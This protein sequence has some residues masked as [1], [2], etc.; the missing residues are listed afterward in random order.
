VNG[1]EFWRRLERRHPRRMTRI[2]RDLVETPEQRQQ[3]EALKE[4]ER[5]RREL[6]KIGYT[7]EEF[8]E[9]A[10]ALGRRWARKTRRT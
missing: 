1:D 2:L 8:E 7:P 6:A 4:E 5:L 3:R 9:A 10:E